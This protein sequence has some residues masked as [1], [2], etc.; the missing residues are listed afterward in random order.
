MKQIL[1]IFSLAFSTLMSQSQTT[2]NVDKIL[3]EKSTVSLWDLTH[4]SKSVIRPTDS[5]KL[6][7]ISLVAIG[8]ASVMWSLPYNGHW[9][10]DGKVKRGE[11]YLYGGLTAVG[12]GIL[13]NETLTYTYRYENIKMDFCPAYASISINF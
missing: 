13:I 6:V 1:I 7:S 8:T 4:T 11:V 9:E 2:S 3:L 5:W 10:F 12:L